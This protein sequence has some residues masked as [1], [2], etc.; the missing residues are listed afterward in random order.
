MSAINFQTYNASAGAG[1]TYSL[2]RNYLKICLRSKNPNAFRSILA[3]TFTNKAAQEMKDRIIRALTSFSNYPNSGKDSGMFADLCKEFELKE[4]ELKERSNKVLRQILHQYSAF[5]VSTI[6]KFT[7]RLI[8]TF[9][10][11]LKLSV[12]YEVELDSGKILEEAIEKM[13]FDLKEDKALAKILI[14]YLNSQLEQGKSPR[15]E[16]PLKTMA[17]NLFQENSIPAIRELKNISNQEFINI[18]QKLYDRNLKIEE[19]SKEMAKHNLDYIDSLGIPRDL[20]SRGFLS[21]FLVES[22]SGEFKLPNNSVKKQIREDAALYPKTKKREGELLID[23]HKEELLKK[24]KSYLNFLEDNFSLYTISKMILA[25]IMGMAVL[26]EI[27]KNL[28]EIK[29]DSNRLPIGEFN[30]LVSERLRDQPAAFLYER[31]GDKYNNYFIDEFQDTSILQWHNLQPLVNNAMS[32]GGTTMLVGDGKQAIYRWRGGE[33]E[34]FLNLSNNSD[35]GNKIKTTKGEIELY[36]RETIKLPFNWRSKKE[37]VDFN[38]EFFQNII[39]AKDSNNN[40]LISNPQ[41]RELFKQSQQEVQSGEG[42]FVSIKNVNYSSDNKEAYVLSQNMEV[43]EI[44]LGALERGYNLKDIAVLT[45]NKKNSASISNFLINNDID[46]ISPDS[47]SLGESAEVCAFIS[48][49]Q[50][51][52]RPDDKEGALVFWNWLFDK[53]EQQEQGERHSFLKSKITLNTEAILNWLVEENV[54]FNAQKWFA[55]S[56]S[57]KVYDFCQYFELSYQND[58]FLQSLLDASYHYECNEDEGETGFIRWWEKTGMNYLVDLPEDLNAVNM[59]TIHKSK[60]LE[61]PIVILAYA[62]WRAFSE[63]DSESWLSLPPEDYFGLPVAKVGLKEIKEELEGFDVYKEIYSQNKQ[64]IV[65][66]NLN[67]LYVAFTRPMDELYIIGAKGYK[68][69]TS[70]VGHYLDHFKKIKGLEGNEGYCQGEMEVKEEKIELRPAE[71]LSYTINQEAEKVKTAVDAPKDWKKGES[72]STVWG[73]KVHQI[74]S[75]IKTHKDLNT[76]LQ[77][78]KDDSFLEVEDFL[79]IEQMVKAVINHDKLKQHFEEG[80]EILNEN[81]I[82]IPASKSLQPDRIVIKDGRFSIL[83]Y[84]TGKAYPS[85]KDQVL[86]YSQVLQKMGFN[87]EACFIIYLDDEIK[88]LEL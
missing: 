55:K 22:I 70:R 24:L 80:G 87:K 1:K 30:K 84:K 27:E 58:P 65:L 16:E 7:N 51:F 46:I 41:H 33:V 13:L 37:I 32:Q 83:E 35:T 85:H 69:D 79:K 17:Y 20:F 34:Q 72:S 74:L 54:E 73:K 25:N 42:G 11:D 62:D 28:E 4:E 57:E 3:I 76:I 53:K 49:L 29:K 45:R 2:V 39:D 43:Y 21:K 50:L 14:Q 8:R 64:D 61:F 67:L 12:N 56:L 31:I 81:E 36:P 60:G 66:D 5:S 44:V 78:M 18:R 19:Q 6:D 15:T 9:A 82:L 77:K 40:L 48:F 75:E 10:Q 52:L 68:D 86:A 26:K 23:P 47:L 59:I 71:I 63:K 88:L 38:N